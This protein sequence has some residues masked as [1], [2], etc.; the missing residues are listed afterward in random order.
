MPSQDEGLLV[1]WHQSYDGTDPHHHFAR[2]GL[3]AYS[4]CS[5]IHSRNLAVDILKSMCKMLS[6]K[7]NTTKNGRSG[8]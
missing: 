4:L 8:R 7:C 5:G 1:G 6:A 2:M 3:K